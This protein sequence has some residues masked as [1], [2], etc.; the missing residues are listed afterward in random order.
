MAEVFSRLHDLAADALEAAHKCGSVLDVEPRCNGM[1]SK[2]SAAFYAELD[3][4]VLAA[5]MCDIDVA[6]KV[7]TDAERGTE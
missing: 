3:R 5:E 6:Y 1:C 4:V 2:Q 7:V